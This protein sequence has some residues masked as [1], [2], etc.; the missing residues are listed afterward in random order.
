MRG[1]GG[2]RLKKEKSTDTDDTEVRR[3]GGIG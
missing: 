3:R 1:D 2:I